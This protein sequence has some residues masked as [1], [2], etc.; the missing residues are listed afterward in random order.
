MTRARQAMGRAGEASVARWYVS[1]GYR[2]LE[3]NWRCGR[4]ELDLVVT[5]GDQLVVCEVKTRTTDRLGSGF[6]AVTGDKQAR[7]RSLT[8]SYLA[9]HPWSGPVRFDVASVV[10]GRIDVMVGAF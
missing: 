8:R 3:R 7:I 1:Q 10:G 9:A 5:D 2:V 6:E 4:G